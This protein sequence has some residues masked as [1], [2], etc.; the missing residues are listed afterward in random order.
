MSTTSPSKKPIVSKSGLLWPWVCQPGELAMATDRLML[1]RSRLLNQPILRFYQWS[2]PT[3]SLGYHQLG[4]SVSQAV[5]QPAIATVQRPTGGRAVLHQAGGERADL[6]YAIAWPQLPR[7]NAYAWLCQFL[8]QGLATLGFELSLGHSRS[9]GYIGERSCFRTATAADLCWQGKKVVGSAQVW[10]QGTV[11]Q[12][13]TILLKPDWQL[14]EQVLPGSTSQ[15][16]GLDCEPEIVIGALLEAAQ[17]C[18]HT[19]WLLDSQG[20]GIY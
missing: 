5:T 3:L 1:T 14:W 7:Q 10:Q 4:D 20:H 6:T 11:L 8:V 16:I 15:V 17:T 13:G 19:E 9:R 12:H 18:W 2:E